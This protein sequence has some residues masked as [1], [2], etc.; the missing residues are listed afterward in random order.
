MYD[1]DR[2]RNPAFSNMSFAEWGKTIN[3]LSGSN[4]MAQAV[5]DSLVK[6]AFAR[7]GQAVDWTGAPNASQDLFGGIG[8]L[9]GLEK[10]LGDAGRSFPRALVNMAP[11]IIGSAL[12]P[13]TGG[14]SAYIGTGLTSAMMAG[15]TYEQTG[16]AKLAALS[17]VTGALMPGVAGRAGQAALRGTGATLTDSAG[18]LIAETTAQKLAG[19]GAAQAGAFGLQEASYQLGNLYSKGELD[20]SKQH[21]LESI[22]SQLPFLAMDAGTGALRPVSPEVVQAAKSAQKTRQMS[23]TLN[24]M[25]QQFAGVHL[26]EG[27][28]EFTRGVQPFLDPTQDLNALFNAVTNA[29]TNREITGQISNEVGSYR[30][31]LQRNQQAAPAYTPP[32]DRVLPE[33]TPSSG[34]QFRPLST[35]GVPN[36]NEFLGQQANF[37]P[38]IPELPVPQ[39]QSGSY[40]EQMRQNQQAP[41][42]FTPFKLE[43]PVLPPTPKPPQPSAELRAASERAKDLLYQKE[44]APEPVVKAKGPEKTLLGKPIPE[45]VVPPAPITPVKTKLASKPAASTE[46]TAV[47]TPVAAT[48]AP[49]TGSVDRI[50]AAVRATEPKGPIPAEVVQQASTL[51][52]DADARSAIAKINKAYKDIFEPTYG[53]KNVQLARLNDAE[54]QSLIK[55]YMDEGHTLDEA[56]QNTLENINQALEDGINDQQF[57]AESAE[58]ARISDEYET[59]VIKGSMDNLN[60]IQNTWDSMPKEVREQMGRSPIEW[61][62]KWR[63][64]IIDRNRNYSK[65]AEVDTAVLE[66]A[67]NMRWENGQWYTDKGVP[68]NE[69]GAKAYLKNAAQFAYKKVIKEQSGGTEVVKDR[70][71]NEIVKP[72]NELARSVDALNDELG[73][74][75]DYRYEVQ[76]ITE[77]TGGIQRRPTGMGKLVKRY[78]KLKSVDEGD[79]SQVTREMSEEGEV[80]PDSEEWHGETKGEGGPDKDIGYDMDDSGELKFTDGR[81]E[82]ERA[83]D[84]VKEVEADSDKAAADVVAQQKYNIFRNMVDRLKPLDKTVQEM[85]V[86]NVGSLVS[87]AKVMLA[88]IMD[89]RLGA[90]KDEIRW[91]DVWEDMQMLPED[92]RFQSTKEMANWWNSTGKEFLFGSKGW[93]ARQPEIMMLHEGKPVS[94]V[95]AEM[96]KRAA[97]K[98]ANRTV[99][100]VK[101]G[102][103]PLTKAERIAKK[104]PSLFDTSEGISAARTQSGQL[105]VRTRRQLSGVND[106]LMSSLDFARKY[107]SRKGESRENAELHAQGVERFLKMAGV[108][109]SAQDANL[110]VSSERYDPKQKD[111]LL[112]LAMSFDLDGQW[113]SIIELMPR[114]YNTDVEG[115][116]Y[117]LVAGHEAWHTVEGKAAR[118]T[119][120]KSEQAAF[121][122]IGELAR[123]LNPEE[124]MALLKQASKI[125]P[126]NVWA[127]KF[128]NETTNG[129]LQYSAADARE[130]TSTLAGLYSA[131]VA[132]GAAPKRTANLL[133]HLVYGDGAVSKFMQML[134]RGAHKLVGAVRGIFSSSKQ[135]VVNEERLN[136]KQKVKLDKLHKAFGELSRTPKEVQDAVRQLTTMDAMQPDSIENALKSGMDGD[137]F[138]FKNDQ[139]LSSAADVMYGKMLKPGDPND[140]GKVKEFAYDFMQLAEVHPELRPFVVESLSYQGKARNAAEDAMS[141][142]FERNY[143]NGKLVPT[144]AQKSL[145]EVSKSHAMR[146]AL[147]EQLAD[148]QTQ[149]KLLSPQEAQA[150]YRKQGLTPEQQRH[151]SDV[152]QAL[153]ESHKIVADQIKR[154]MKDSLVNATARIL[155]VGKDVPYKKALE[156][157]DTMVSLQL[158]A[159]GTIP[160]PMGVD[161]NTLMQSVLASG[162]D[163]QKISVANNA[164]IGLGDKYKALVD[165]LKDREWFI[166][167]QRFGRHAA[168]YT[169]D[170]KSGRI[171]ADTRAELE[172][173]IDQL[174]RDNPNIAEPQRYDNSNQATVGLNPTIAKSI[175]DLGREAFERVRGTMPAD[176][177]AKAQEA[178]EAFE[179]TMEKELAA[180]GIGKW[181]QERKGAEGKEY[182]DMLENSM[183]YL[184]MVPHALSKTWLKDRASVV[185]LDPQVQQNPSAARIGEQQIKNILAPESPVSRKVREWTFLYYLGSNLSSAMLETAQPM[186]AVPAQLQRNGAGVGE[187]FGYLK[188]AYKQVAKSFKDKKYDNQFVDQMMQKLENTGLLDT[189]TT[190][191]F[192][193]HSDLGGVNLSKATDGNLNFSTAKD[194]MSNAVGHISSFSKNLY[195]RATAVSSRVTAA[196]ASLHAEKLVKEGKLK[197]EEAY[198][199]VVR[200][201]TL[202]A[203]GVAGRAARPTG[204]YNGQWINRSAA[205][206]MGSL[207]G[208]T[209][210]MWSMFHRMAKDAVSSG[211]M[212]SKESKAFMTLAGTQLLAAGLLGLPGVGTAFNAVNEWFPELEVKKNLREGISSIFGKDNELGSFFSDLSLR[213]LPTVMSGVDTSGR[214]G[215]ANMLGVSSYDGFQLKNLFGAPGGILGNLGT[216]AQQAATGEFSKAAETA[217][218]TALKNILKL[219]R[220]G[221]DVRD[222]NGALRYEP[223]TAEQ[224]A[225][226][227]GFTPKR[228]ADFREMDALTSQMEEVGKS[229]MNR[230][231]NQL[232]EMLEQKKFGEVRQMLLD[233]EKA[234][235][236]EF[237]ATEGLKIAIQRWQDRTMPEDPMRGG[238]KA[239]MNERAALMQTFNQQSVPN[240]ALR[241]QQSAQMQQMFGLSGGL[242]KSSMMKAMLTDDLMAK[243]P[244]M[245]RAQA[246]ARIEEMFRRTP[247][248]QLR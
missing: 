141:P 157:A 60:K 212:T 2:A 192:F 16:D 62:L 231:Y 26:P 175:S 66:A 126:D 162:M 63:S 230:F 113:K 38:A 44:G 36:I 127:D 178:F 179:T 215:L 150:V 213:G 154:G 8:S 248:Q 219:Y 68:V 170:G 50:M 53:V 123:S 39:F 156:A 28:S 117:G 103:K 94:E 22:V 46:P 149:K 148:E 193:D 90:N 194:M 25:N 97:E 143:I 234:E 171:S 167:E 119:L 242:N 121:E 142:F 93:L 9:I 132:D 189:Q 21:F 72:L 164:L 169:K 112:G 240:E 12:A 14:A 183:K 10:E 85:G 43:L 96:D 131:A 236:D 239:T 176:E 125:L 77:D 220:N 221:G 65:Y 195:S 115:S 172:A 55:E 89:Q 203:P 4:I 182:L 102:L 159:N 198:D 246:R 229:R 48:P 210:T 155:M 41:A 82:I 27:T 166:S 88:H 81:T 80:S 244:Q 32:A 31:G 138:Q 75:S 91:A 73:D 104:D 232:G 190:G 174:K 181:T 3:Q 186:M 105:P 99:M 78:S 224:L 201:L 47:P 17:G 191:Y 51:R 83:R 86:Y 199:Y 235:P 177:A 247:E 69:R 20:L 108:F 35:E 70:D 168:T 153:T 200:T 30:E 74:T 64:D 218:P 233:K 238:T 52:Q 111:T 56:V 54:I 206:M 226:A 24:Q 71:G 87:R 160:L 158:N 184:S 7:L 29:R 136:S 228:V 188:D 144:A 151:V 1:E 135:G 241:L 133:D 59:G 129:F 100:A 101:G 110:T 205:G 40:A 139:E 5:D 13:V 243:N 118:G 109:K 6:G 61:I 19:Y 49:E 18:K 130:F 33:Y 204:F 79:D 225:M 217:S 227:V 58:Q 140:I 106:I 120:S 114:E 163:P 197:P 84:A 161:P 15:E 165:Q 23:E 180:K 92:F 237:N 145:T 146:K 95:A 187:S 134:Y 207:Q 152:R 11:M 98:A 245:T 209:M 128:A 124:R 45:P 222:S 185:G 214:L 216:A 173:K 42:S 137:R 196:A 211:S 57:R 37:Q 122:Q 202:T 116:M 67:D 223:N 34:Q 76:E 208:F 107:F 147:H